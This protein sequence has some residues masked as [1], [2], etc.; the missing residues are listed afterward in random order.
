MKEISKHD[1]ISITAPRRFGKSTNTGMLKTFFEIVVDRNGNKIDSVE[2]DGNGNIFEKPQEHLTENFKLFKTHNLSVYQDKAFFYN[3]CGQHPVIYIS[4]KSVNG[5]TP[6][7][8]LRS[9]RTTVHNV[10][11]QHGYLLN[12]KNIWTNDSAMFD[13]YYDTV[14]HRELTEKELIVSLQYLSEILHKHFNKTVLVLIDDLDA[15]ILKQIYNSNQG[16]K[17]IVDLTAKI[18]S[19][20]LK[21]NDHVNRGVIHACTEMEKIISD[22]AGNITHFPFLHNHKFGEFYG[23]TESEV[24]SLVNKFKPS[25]NLKE[26]ERW[27]GGYKVSG[28]HVKIYNVWSVVNYFK[29]G[30]LQS[31]WSASTELKNLDKMCSTEYIKFMINDL[32]N[33]R[34]ICIESETHPTIRHVL[35]LDVFINSYMASEEDTEI[36]KDTW[37]FVQFLYNVGYFNIVHIRFYQN[38]LCLEIPNTEIGQQLAT[39]FYTISYFKNKFKIRSEQIDSYNKALD[40][41]NN[42]R[43]TFEEFVKSV[44]ILFSNTT[45]IWPEN[46]IEFHRLLLT[47]AKTYP[48]FQQVNGELYDKSFDNLFILIIRQDG[49]AIIMRVHYNEVTANESLRYI[50]SKNLNIK[51]DKYRERVIY[52]GLSLDKSR[53]IHL[54]YLTNSTDSKQAVDISN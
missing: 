24:N 26:I 27:Y 20:L 9:V 49:T 18:I 17:L 53:K 45:K 46:E 22:Q 13:K 52:M 34:V 44:A 16:L 29:Q 50:F 11:L 40:L 32:L 30:V 4:F 54:S 6:E 28:T 12:C 14:Q 48:H 8:V 42:N 3:N 23:L 25:H 38:A 47:L 5:Y 35:D 2:K 19:K 31:Y 51:H 21:R 37:F 43:N 33:N 39:Q 41:L 7:D 1:F 10:F 36:G 15:P